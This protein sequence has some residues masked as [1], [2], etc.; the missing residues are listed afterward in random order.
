[1]RSLSESVSFAP[2]DSGTAVR[3]VVRATKREEK[4]PGS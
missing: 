3:I 2:T 1:M 4:N